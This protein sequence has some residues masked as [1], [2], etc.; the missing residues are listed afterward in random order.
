MEVIVVVV[1]P[2]WCSESGLLL[3]QVCTDSTLRGLYAAFPHTP[4]RAQA[5]TCCM[6]REPLSSTKKGRGGFVFSSPTVQGQ[7]R[8][9]GL[10]EC[11]PDGRP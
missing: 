11:Q 8:F 9:P 3:F 1:P 4:G 6:L 10:P 5:R 7:V 2:F